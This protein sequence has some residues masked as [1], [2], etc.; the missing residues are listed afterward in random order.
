V[1]VRA[2]TVLTL[3]FLVALCVGV[4]PAGA[5]TK[6]GGLD[7]GFGH[8]GVAA[9]A[10]PRSAGGLKS[11]KIG[12]GGR[13]YA[14][15][16]STILALRSDGKPARG[17]GDGGKVTIVPD[18]SEG[19]PSR[20]A[21]DS[22]GRLLV[23]GST[24]LK[25]RK[26]YTGYVIRLLPDGSRDAGFGNGGEVDLD[27]GLPVLEDG[28]APSVD[29][30]AF[31]IDAQDRPLVA[32]SFGPPDVICAFGMGPTPF[33]ARLT[34]AG[35][36]DRSFDGTGYLAFEGHGVVSSLGLLPGGAPAVFTTPCSTGARVEW[37]PPT[38]ST[39]TEAG[40]LSG[41]A[42]DRGL[43]F[44]YLDPTVE[45]SGDIFELQSPSPAGEGADSLARYLPNGERDPGF[46]NGGS[47][48]LHR[49]YK[50]VEAYAVDAE[51]RPII[52][53]GGGVV[54]RRFRQG[55]GLDPTFGPGGKLTA[56]SAAPRVIVL[57]PQ[58]RIYTAGVKRDG[59][60]RTIQVARFIPAG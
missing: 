16:G 17:F 30:D 41:L 60:R 53:A 12:P 26:G 34:E 23:D 15:D 55:G 42:T 50:E 38:Y 28:S 40:A 7:R 11:V 9:I 57:D 49:P 37:Q 18:G 36:V 3:A 35:A 48:T 2:R 59:K 13:I 22:R 54:L 32:G 56:K 14:L 47:V 51:G 46:G 39:L 44:S 43:G 31:A 52:A 25:G 5:A 19:E 29:V 20:F 45:P 27:L 58:G 8:R 4:A 21:V 10:V 6:V 1:I 33:V 24:H